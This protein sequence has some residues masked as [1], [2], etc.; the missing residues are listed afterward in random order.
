MKNILLTRVLP[1]ILG[2]LVGMAIVLLAGCTPN[3]SIVGM[4]QEKRPTVE[5]ITFY[6]PNSE[7]EVFETSKIFSF[8]TDY[9]SFQTTAGVGVEVH[10]VWKVEPLR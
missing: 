5:R 9:V 4:Y 2:A 10:G 1:M 7:P 3:T 6:P 8:G